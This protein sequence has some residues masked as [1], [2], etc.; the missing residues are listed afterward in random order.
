MW[1]MIMF[2]VSTA[3]HTAVPINWISNYSHSSANIVNL[4]LLNNASVQL[5]NLICIQYA[6][7]E[8]CMFMNIDENTS[9]L[10]EID[11]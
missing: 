9:A 11:E 5:F 10:S 6:K 7:Y 1:I 3:T 4:L 8:I 2:M